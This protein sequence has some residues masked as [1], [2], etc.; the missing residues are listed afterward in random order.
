MVG[1]QKSGFCFLHEIK[2]TANKGRGVFACEPIKQGSIAWRHIPGQYTVFNEATFKA[3]I[4]TM[5]HEDVVYEL[6][7]V[8]KL[9]EMP[10]CLIRVYDGCE[11]INHAGHAN[12]IT[13][14]TP[15]IESPFDTGSDQYVQN[16]TQALLADRYAV[17]ATRDIDKG[18]EFTM[19]YFAS[20]IDDPDFY[21][22]LYEQYGVTE[23]YLDD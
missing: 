15:A 16:V 11:L 10:D 14:N 1:A 9:P 8:F 21:G 7:H 19:D 17:V 18:E 4:E 5:T 13:N 20:G 12:L 23:T 2:M 22:T 6:T 3:A